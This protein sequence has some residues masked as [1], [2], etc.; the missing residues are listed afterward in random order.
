[1]PL[2][3]LLI[4]GALLVGFVL[5]AW[6]HIRR[7]MMNSIIPFVMRH[8][9]LVGEMLGNLMFYLD[10]N[11]SATREYIRTTWRAVRQLV[12]GSKTIY[13]QKEG[14]SFTS[15]TTTVLNTGEEKLKIQQVETEL[16]WEE[17]P[18][19]I[20]REFMVEGRQ[21]ARLDIF[22]AVETKLKSKDPLILEV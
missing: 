4:A 21:E 16:D 20:R 10:G 3:I 12:V 9:K 7:L 5:A 17:I 19:D 18:A 8:S 2:P 14:N 11:L 6:P 15:A 13:R 22:D 1:M